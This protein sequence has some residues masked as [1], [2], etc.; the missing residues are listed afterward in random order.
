ME[1]SLPVVEYTPESQLANPRRL[2]RAMLHDLSASRELAWRLFVRNLSAKYRQT[3]LG[4]VWA[5]LP[6][7]LTTA[8]F[9]YLHRAGYFSVGSMKVP[10]VAFVFSGIVLWQVFT[11]A[12][13]MPLR[14]VQQS[15]SILTKVNFPREALILAGLGEV[16]FGFLIRS[17]ILA[18]VFIW[19]ALP[20]GVGL[21]ASIGG[22]LAL[23]A[24]GLTVGLV[25]TPLALL[26]HD[27][28]EALPFVLYL[29]MF[30]TPV[31]YPAPASALGSLAMRFNPVGSVLDTTRAWLLG[32]EAQYLSDFAI[33]CLLTV[34]ALLAGW[35]IYR[36]AL[37]ILIER[38]TS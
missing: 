13:L 8:V 18:V 2:V 28:R 25:L 30:L 4:Y 7:I 11:E 3:L 37:P 9:V 17:I 33:M 27:I 15:M 26:Y 12:L 21:I 14:M 20:V 32:V 23:I 34:G 38:I 22:V 29:W 6:P 10:Y 35:L 36:L 16:F 5:F 19:Y 1:K 24:L 31:L